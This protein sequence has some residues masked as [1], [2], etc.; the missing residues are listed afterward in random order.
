MS[1]IKKYLTFFDK[2]EEYEQYTGST[3][4]IKPNVSRCEEDKHVHYGHKGYPTS[5]TFIESSVTVNIEDKEIQIEAII[6]PADV[7]NKAVIWKTSN[8]DIATVDNKG[9]VTLK[10]P[11]NFVV[12]AKTIDGESCALCKVNCFKIVPEEIQLN[13][14]ILYMS[15][16]DTYQLEAAI[17]PPEASQEV[18]WSSS[19]PTAVT[20]DNNGLVEALVI[21]GNSIITAKSVERPIITATCITEVAYTPVT[22]VQISNSAITMGSGSTYQLTANVLPERASV[23]GVTWSSSN[24][25]A[26]TVDDNGLVTCNVMSGDDVTIIVTTDEG[27]FTAACNVHIEHVPVTGIILNKDTMRMKS[28]ETKTLDAYVLPVDASN[29]RVTWESSDPTIATVDSNGVVTS[30]SY[31][32]CNISAITE[33]GS[34]AAACSV[35]VKEPITGYF[36]IRFNSTVASKVLKASGFNNL[37]GSIDSGETWTPIDG[38]VQYDDNYTLMLRNRRVDTTARVGTFSGSSFAGEL[39]GNILS[40]V[41]GD[42]FINHTGDTTIEGSSVFNGLFRECQSYIDASG[43]VL[44]VMGDD[45]TY[46][47]MFYQNQ[48]DGRYYSCTAAPELPNTSV[49]RSSYSYMF[50]NCGKLVT[51]P[52]LP[53]SVVEE[54][55]YCGMFRG[56]SKLLVTPKLNVTSVGDSG[57]TE[58][59]ALCTSL[60]AAPELPATT[61]GNNGYGYMFSGCT[62]LVVAPEYVYSSGGER[63]CNHMFYQCTSLKTPPALPSTNVGVS[64]YVSMFMDSSINVLPTLPA[65]TLKMSCYS[66]MFYNCKGIKEIPE[67]YLPNTELEVSCYHSMFYGCYLEKVPK[68]LLPATTVPNS[69]YTQMFSINNLTELPD[70]P[71]TTIGNGSYWGMFSAS[72]NLVDASGLELPAMTLSSNCYR[73]MF[74]NSK[75]IEKAPVLSAATL[76]SY[77]YAGMFSG[78]TNINYIKCTAT[79]I[80]GSATPTSGWLK[81]ASTTGTFVKAASTTWSRGTSGIPSGW[82]VQN[83]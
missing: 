62:N 12:M 47:Y 2:H 80:P 81:D 33:E 22:G 66:G 36:S 4:Y 17:L 83:A 72:Q 32:S 71:A 61:V 74:A 49:T 38:T 20:V 24:P 16:G 58:M 42:D 18:E 44:D 52:E 8:L 73:N 75:K 41:Y 65:T 15:S 67:N 5:V 57:C 78:C 82:T 63:A 48:G 27:S 25:T 11:G 23:K 40:L 46:A 28:G 50:A 53:A 54:R 26:V 79:T 6:E 59:F 55:A 34:F 64:G 56:C 9:L 13:K 10:K 45:F 77:C 76:V 60:T 70:L 29:K 69:A 30:L 43:L 68:N 31:G 19:N 3:E 21:S 7:K 39:G 1:D 51:P 35:N 37:E 14:N